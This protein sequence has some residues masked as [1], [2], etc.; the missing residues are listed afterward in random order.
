MCNEFK[1]LA[2][3]VCRALIHPR[4]GAGVC[5]IWLCETSG[6]GKT[7]F[8]GST[9]VPVFSPSHRTRIPSCMGLAGRPVTNRA[10]HPL[11][12]SRSDGTYTPST[13]SNHRNSGLCARGST[14]RTVSSG[15]DIFVP[16]ISTPRLPGAASSG[17]VG[18]TV[19]R[20]TGGDARSIPPSARVR[21]T[22]TDRRPLVR[23]VRIY[24]RS[25]RAATGTLS[26]TKRTIT[27]TTGAAYR[28]VRA[29]T[30][31]MGAT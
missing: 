18:R 14:V 15:A 20:T 16:G 27:G 9:A 8:L 21:L 30:A 10:C 7:V 22:R 28:T 6:C 24:G 1:E 4:L 2:K 11:T 5:P 26:T 23:T 3:G 12:G 17:S 13:L 19:G 31:T 25:M 29:T